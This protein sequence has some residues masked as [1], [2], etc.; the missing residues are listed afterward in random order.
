MRTFKPCRGEFGK[1]TFVRRRYARVK[2]RL[3]ANCDLQRPLGKLSRWKLNPITYTGVIAVVKNDI[4]RSPCSAAVWIGEAKGLRLNHIAIAAN[5]RHIR[6]AGKI[7]PPH[8]C[9]GRPIKN[10]TP[11][12]GSEDIK[13][14][15]SRPH[16]QYAPLSGYFFEKLQSKPA[17]GGKLTAPVEYFAN[18][19]AARDVCGAH[20]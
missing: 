15:S 3:P 14:I 2:R 16:R 11:S 19:A 6:S 10:P 9:Y 1:K 18:T 17:S 13:P 4:L 5:G 8:F 20:T 12:A 7:C